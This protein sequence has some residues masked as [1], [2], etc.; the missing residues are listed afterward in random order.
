MLA[1]LFRYPS[2]LFHHDTCSYQKIDEKLAFSSNL[3][4]YQ[5]NSSV[6]LTFFV[7]RFHL[8]YDYQTLAVSTSSLGVMRPKAVS[9]RERR[10]QQQQQPERILSYPFS[11]QL[12][13]MSR[14]ASRMLIYRRLSMSP[15]QISELN[16]VRVD[17][18]YDFRAFP[19]LF[20]LCWPLMKIGY[21]WGYLF[22]LVNNYMWHVL[23]SCLCVSSVCRNSLSRIIAFQL[24]TREK[25]FTLPSV[26]WVRK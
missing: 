13:R 15:T 19:G 14:R 1:S 21:S 3:A 18:R 12:A 11:N 20:V 7:A 6:H 17:P 24:D 16:L 4:S 8:I 5:L 2:H 26:G 10:Q 23:E 9:I 25:P 22:Y